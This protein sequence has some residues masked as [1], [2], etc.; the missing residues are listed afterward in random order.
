MG[1]QKEKNT[2]VIQCEAGNQTSAGA[3]RAARDVFFACPAETQRRLLEQADKMPEEFKDSVIKTYKSFF[4]LSEMDWNEREQ[5][6]ADYFSTLVELLD[7][8]G[9]ERNASRGETSDYSRGVEE[10]YLLGCERNK[11]TNR[12]SISPW[13]PVRVMNALVEHELEHML[14]KT[15]GVRHAVLEAVFAAQN[16][17]R[18]QIK[19]FCRNQVYEALA[20]DPYGPAEAYAF[21]QREGNTDIPYLRIWEKIHSFQASHPAQGSPSEQ[22]E[23]RIAVFGS[24]SGESESV[25]RLLNP[26]IKIRWTEFKNIPYMGEYYFQDEAGEQLFD[27]SNLDDARELAGKYD[28]ILF[29][30][31]NCLYRQWQSPKTVEERN[32]RT[33]CRWC[34]DRSTAREDFKEKAAYYRD[35]YH[36]TGL[37]LNS[38]RQSDSSSFEFDAE[39]FQNLLAVSEE[40]ADIYLYIREGSSI[41]SRDLK[42]SSV[43]NDEY[44]AGRRLLVYKLAKTDEK[45]FNEKYGKFLAYSREEI[46]E[47]RQRYVSL[48][49]WKILKSIGNDYCRAF[50]AEV[51]KATDVSEDCLIKRLNQ[52]ALMLQYEI[53]A[54]VKRI[55]IHYGIVLFEEGWDEKQKEIFRNRAEELAEAVLDFALK[56]GGMYCVKRYFRELLIHSVIVN[57]DSVS[58]LVFAHLWSQPWMEICKGKKLPGVTPLRQDDL[59]G[60]HK[61]HRTVFVTVER[62][63]NLRMRRVPDMRGYFINTFRGMVCPEVNEDNFE[64]TLHCIAECC[65]KFHYTGSSLYLNSTL[66]NE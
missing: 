23:I 37:W 66:I 42:Y 12:Y 48:N 58:D 26:E 40:R 18:Q 52:S 10:L 39:L 43:C 61:L 32:V 47:K 30:D 45:A 22:R 17:N 55:D 33:Y 54:E 24:L 56:A 50:L 7:A 3:D 29:L 49:L 13:H 44:Y 31:I 11:N 27:L 53:N 28:I 41:A 60:R 35:I 19:L 21:R 5:V 4:G 64:Q 51:S 16:R 62:L 9:E 8:A 34:L 14:S 38:L 20:E 36:Y 6:V 2:T 15:E 25:E 57:A 65:E 1:D 46:Q 59:F 63:E